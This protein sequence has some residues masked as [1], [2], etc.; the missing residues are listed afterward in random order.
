M[1]IIKGKILLLALVLIIA[2]VTVTAYHVTPSNSQ[3]GQSNVPNLENQVS[4]SLKDNSQSEVSNT[5]LKSD[6]SFKSYSNSPNKSNSNSGKESSTKKYTYS[7]SDVKTS[8]PQSIAQKYI[9]EPGAVAGTPEKVNIGGK[10][11]DAVPVL[12]KGKTVGEIDIDP[13]TGKNVGGAGGAPN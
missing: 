7:K 4:T 12:I 1:V 11:V 8:D 10:C 2:S 5:G 13:K 9:E 6:K 3:L